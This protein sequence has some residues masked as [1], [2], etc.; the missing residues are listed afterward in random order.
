ML[1]V[2]LLRNKYHVMSDRLKVSNKKI[3]VGN[4]LDGFL[5]ILVCVK[6]IW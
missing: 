2:K 4:N 3:F 5:S 6:S 1:S